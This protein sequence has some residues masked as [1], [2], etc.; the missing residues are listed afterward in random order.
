M[1]NAEQKKALLRAAREAVNAA[2]NGHVYT[3]AT[4]DPVLQRPAAAFVTL[5]NSGELRGCIGMVQPELPLFQAVA[6]MAREAALND[7]RFNSVTPREVEALHIEISVLTPAEPVRDPA[8][9]EV[10]VHGLIVEQGARRGLL[11]P[12]VATEWGWDRDEFL[13][14]TCLK[15]GLPREAWRRGARV[16]RFG[17]EVF[18]EDRGV[19]SRGVEESKGGGMQW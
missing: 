7:F 1:L 16:L 6:E 4:D 8:D 19:E 5:H 3:P 11:L 14:H 12:Q 10:G 15:A 18:G 17:A 9:I 2:V 13:D